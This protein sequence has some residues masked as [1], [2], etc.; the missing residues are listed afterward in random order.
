MVYVVLDTEGFIYGIYEEYVDAQDRA[1]E[2]QADDI[3][4]GIEEYQLNKD[5]D[6]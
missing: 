3:D 1:D 5:I 6:D 4:A 2:L